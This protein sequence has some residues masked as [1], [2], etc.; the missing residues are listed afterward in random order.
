MIPNAPNITRTGPI[1]SWDDPAF[2]DAVRAT[3][4]EKNIMAGV[5]T[6]VS[7]YVP[8]LSAHAQGY[9]V[10][11]VYDAFGAADTLSEVTSCIRLQRAGA[12]VINWLRLMVM[13]KGQWRR[14]TP[15]R[16]TREVSRD[17]VPTFRW[18]LANRDDTRARSKREAV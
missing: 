18:L 8:T 13:R 7:F 11:A 5:T 3:G 6:H 15:E 14:R 17:R 12:I 16:M 1:N 9:D 4:R 10:Y 2:R